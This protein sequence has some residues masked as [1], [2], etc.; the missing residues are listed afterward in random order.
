MADLISQLSNQGSRRSPEMEEW[1]AALS[2]E[3]TSRMLQAETDS[4]RNDIAIGHLVRAIQEIKDRLDKVEGRAG[5]QPGGGG[6][7]KVAKA[8][9]GKSTKR[10][11]RKSKN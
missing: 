8:K 3:E 10:R 9:K 11:R 1:R 4:T 2:A 6:K 5:T 7:R